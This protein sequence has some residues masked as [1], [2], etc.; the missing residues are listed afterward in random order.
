VQDTPIYVSPDEAIIAVDAYSLATSGRDVHG[1][2]MPLYFQVQMPGEE[3]SG[4]FTPAIFYLS[5]PFLKVLRFSERAIRLPTVIVGVA[6]VV[7]VYFIGR[8]LFPRR[9]SAIVGSVLLLLTPAH[10][11]L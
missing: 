8:R 9:S 5:V 3:R 4:W 11:M 6:N 10:F 1:R 7:L 2:F